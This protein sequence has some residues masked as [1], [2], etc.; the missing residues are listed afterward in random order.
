MTLSAVRAGWHPPITPDGLRVEYMLM[1][2]DS[3][4]RQRTELL[5]DYGDQRG[6]TRFALS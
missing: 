5:P 3:S 2:V 4:A 1:P 6:T